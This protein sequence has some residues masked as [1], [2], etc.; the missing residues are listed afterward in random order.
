MHVSEGNMRDHADHHDA[1]L[2]LRLY[3]LRRETKFRQ[4]R[5]WFM[6]QFQ[7]DSIEDL[8]HKFPSGT[9]ENAY[10]RMVVSYWDMA[11]S[12]VNQGLIKED[13][14]FENTT[15]LWIVWAKVKALAPAMRERRKNPHIWKNHEEL[16]GRFEK[17]M[18]NRAPEALEIL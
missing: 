17:W 12:I 13:F 10:F 6:G 3:D 2:M 11:G 18:D 14:F 8:F 15:E 1:E 7:A 9:P 16:A 4:A 5:E